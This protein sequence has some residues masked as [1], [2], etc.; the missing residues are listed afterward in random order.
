MTVTPKR[1]V[2]GSVTSAPV[3]IGKTPYDYVTSQVPQLIS[4]THDTLVVLERENY[5]I[6]V[7]G[8]HWQV[9][10]T[11]TELEPNT[12]YRVVY[13]H[14]ETASQTGGGAGTAIYVIT[15]PNPNAPVE[16]PEIIGDVNADGAVDTADAKFIIRYLMDTIELDKT[17][18]LAADYNGD[19]NVDTTDVRTL[20]YTLVTT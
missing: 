12:L 17:A 11:F 8:V 20:L 3:I 2:T 4:K 9:S 1:T 18:I 16:E 10:G 5:E 14:G 6:S 13:R 7:D 19:G 15:D